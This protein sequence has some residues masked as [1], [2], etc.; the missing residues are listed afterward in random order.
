MHR[1]HRNI[2]TGADAL[3]LLRDRGLSVELGADGKLLLT[4]LSYIQPEERPELADL[5]RKWRE[6]ILEI[7]REERRLLSLSDAAF[8]AEQVQIR[9]ECWPLTCY[10]TSV[11]QIGIA[12]KAHGLHVVARDDDYTF[13][14]AHCI[15]DK[16][17]PKVFAF[18]RRNSALLNE[19]VRRDHERQ[20]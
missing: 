16:L 6:N 15:P 4:G 2:T 10:Y 8:A 5:A 14:D 19:F 17:L 9:R 12:L 3:W 20:S 18:S 7:V 1:H 11:E 13:V